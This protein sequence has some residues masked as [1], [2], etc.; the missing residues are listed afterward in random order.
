MREEEKI[1]SFTDIVI[2]EEI[3]N[4]RLSKIFLYEKYTNSDQIF[5]RRLQI[6]HMSKLQIIYFSLIQWIC[7]SIQ[8]PNQDHN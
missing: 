5:S 8:T 2:L 3:N 4:F 7:T 6:V 1:R